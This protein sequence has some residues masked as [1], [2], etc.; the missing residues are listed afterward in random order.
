MDSKTFIRNLNSLFCEVNRQGKRYSQVWLSDIDMGGLYQTGKY[1]LNVKAGFLLES[2]FGEM[3]D[4][5]YL[6]RDKACEEMKSIWWVKVHNVGDRVA[7]TSD[8]LLVFEENEN[9]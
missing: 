6:L 4:I 1:E 3:D 5:I 8:D 9:A 2:I 7:C